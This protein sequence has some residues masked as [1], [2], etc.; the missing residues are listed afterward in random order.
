MFWVGEELNFPAKLRLIYA[1]VAA[2][3]FDKNINEN[4]IFLRQLIFAD[5]I[6][7]NH[8]VK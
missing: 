6:L 3:T 7:I 4:E 8:I 2:H 1:L 5:L